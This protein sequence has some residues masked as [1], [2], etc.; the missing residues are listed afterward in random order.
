M[1]ETKEIET[2]ALNGAI[3]QADKEYASMQVKI[4]ALQKVIA[5]L[6]RQR[7]KIEDETRRNRANRRQLERVIALARPQPPEVVAAFAEIYGLTTE[8]ANDEITVKYSSEIKRRMQALED[9]MFAICDHRLVLHVGECRCTEPYNAFFDPEERRCAICGTKERGMAINSP[10]SRSYSFS[11]L[12]NSPER[13][14]VLATE[15]EFRSYA[16]KSLEEVYA[17]FSSPNVI[18]RD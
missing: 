6:Q 13:V 17:R 11:R 15:H 8:L 16:P 5:D 4:G 3:A 2:D 14:V 9:S 1:N 10:L 12:A 18:F 7:E